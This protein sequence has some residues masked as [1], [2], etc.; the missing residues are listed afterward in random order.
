MGV[1]IPPDEDVFESAGDLFQGSHSVDKTN[2][3]ETPVKNETVRL[4]DS[5]DSGKSEKKQPP[6][7]PPR[8]SS[9]RKPDI[10]TKKPDTG[11]PPRRPDAPP[12]RPDVP[13][14]RPDVPPR[15][16]S[17]KTSSGSRTSTNEISHKSDSRN[18]VSSKTHGNASDVSNASNVVSPTPVSPAPVQG[19]RNREPKKVRRVSDSSKQTDV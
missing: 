2:H 11:T 3:N 19:R 5:P 15:R 1:V 8:I 16:E 4:Q 18:P 14:G 12:R 10:L 6:P 7:R 17:G 13:P 9:D